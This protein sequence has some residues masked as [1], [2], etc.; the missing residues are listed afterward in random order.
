MNHLLRRLVQELLRHPM[1][2]IVPFVISLLLVVTTSASAQTA[3]GSTTVACASKAGERQVCPAD[4]SGG[5]AVVRS[6]GTS[7]CLLGKTWGYDNTGV[8]VSDGCAAEF[9]LGASGAAIQASQATAATPPEPERSSYSTFDASGSGFLVGRSNVG[10]LRI[11]GYALV[12]FIN[13][14]GDE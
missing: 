6:T 1:L 13:Q 7:A 3:P 5:V 9:V 14:R 11:G 10:E 8:W 4:T 2:S 12:R